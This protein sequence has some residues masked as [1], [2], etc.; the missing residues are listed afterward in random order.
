MPL[1]SLLA[2]ETC[3]IP[4]AVLGLE[5]AERRIREQKEAV[6]ALGLAVPR[7]VLIIDR[8]TA[9]SRARVERRFAEGT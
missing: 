1:A 3:F 4:G 2:T 8:D 6:R 7:H 9:E 5:E